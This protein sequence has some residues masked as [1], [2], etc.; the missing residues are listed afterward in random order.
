MKLRLIILLAFAVPVL[1]KAGESPGSNSDFQI[2]LPTGISRDVW[3]Y[4][5][6]K[7][8][9]MTAAKV[10]LG[11][12][13]FFDKRLSSDATVSC[14]TCHD[15]A[16]AFADGKPVSEG[17]AGRRGTRNSPSLLNAMFNSGQFWD[18]RA[19]S[20]EDQAVQP[21]VNPDEM[22]DQT[23]EQVV[24]RL[25]AIPEYTRGFQEVFNGPVTIERVGKAIAAFERTLISGNSAFDRFQSGDLQSLSDSA[26]N[27]FMLFRGRGR[28]AV[29]H[30]SSASFPFFSDQNYRNTGVAAANPKFIALVEMAMKLSRSDSKQS[31]DALG[32]QTGGDELGRFLVTGNNI[33]IGAF[34]VPSLRNVE[35]TAP[36]FHDGSARTLSDVVRFY[37]KGGGD[38]PARDWQLESLNLTEQEERDIVEFLKSLTGDE[39]RKAAS[40]PRL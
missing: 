31:L 35:L 4:Y 8:N 26:R 40:S 27:G 39:A 34:R 17:V 37:V 19:E 11:R 12:K 32:K 18:G 33:E 24:A 6:P 3:A 5:I 21:L 20:L 15:P 22:G 23:H 28:C 10:E 16:L 7:T 2:S 29:C 30:T 1:V 9:P 14:A 25:A 13:L 36:Y 38:N